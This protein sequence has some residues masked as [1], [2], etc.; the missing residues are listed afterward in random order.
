MLC[1]LPATTEPTV[2]DLYA[3]VLQVTRAMHYPTASGESAKAIASVQII[4]LALITS[5]L[6]PAVDNVE[7][8][9]NAK[10]K[11][12]WPFVHVRLERKEMHW[13]PVE[14]RKVIR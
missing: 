7:L 10:L 1:A 4:K 11:D 8:G 9:P 13:F 2:R 3:H 12:I 14:L 5:A 6:I